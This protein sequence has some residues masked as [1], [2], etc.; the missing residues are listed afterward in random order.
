M[1][2]VVSISLDQETI[3]KIEDILNKDSFRNKSHVVEEAIKK[4]HRG[5]EE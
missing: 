4:M 3:E 1:K 5:G 2:K